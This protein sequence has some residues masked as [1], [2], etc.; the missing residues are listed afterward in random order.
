MLE[1]WLLVFKFSLKWENSI[2]L[3]EKYLNITGAVVEITYSESKEEEERRYKEKKISHIVWIVKSNDKS[4]FILK[5]MLPY[6][7]FP[8]IF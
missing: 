4:K 5:E 3:G 1:S 8:L 6:V 7:R 2:L